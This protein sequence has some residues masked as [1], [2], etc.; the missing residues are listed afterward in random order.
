MQS[1]DEV[2]DFVP[3]YI[4]FNFDQQMILK[5]EKVRNVRMGDFGTI[6]H[7]TQYGRPLYALLLHTESSSLL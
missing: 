5:D 7:L 3:P 1:L 4:I 2:R 6:E